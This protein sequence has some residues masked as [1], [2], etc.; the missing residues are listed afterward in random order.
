LYRARQRKGLRVFAL[1]QQLRHFV[2]QVTTTAGAANGE[3]VRRW[4]Q[5]KKAGWYAIIGDTGTIINETALNRN[6]LLLD[7]RVLCEKSQQA[8]PDRPDFALGQAVNGRVAFYVGPVLV[9]EVPI[10]A[11]VQAEADVSTADLPDTQVTTDPYQRIFL[12]L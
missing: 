1:G 6:S 7:S 3:R 8:T 12:R 9:A 2:D 5:D 11:H 4:V 10:W